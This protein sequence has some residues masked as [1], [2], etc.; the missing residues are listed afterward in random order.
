MGNKEGARLT[1]LQPPRRR[2]RRRAGLDN[3]RLHDLRYSFASGALFLGEGLPMIGKLL[4][5]TQVQTTA[6][7]TH[8]ALDPVRAA[9]EK[10][11]DFIAKLAGRPAHD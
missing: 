2:I 9:A 4:V 11:S 5:H 10:V 3:V 1:D 8:L 6:R 7:Y